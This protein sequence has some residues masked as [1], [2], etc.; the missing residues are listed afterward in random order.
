MFPCLSTT[1]VSLMLMY[2][3]KMCSLGDI[4]LMK[5]LFFMLQLCR[6]VSGSG[7]GLAFSFV[8]QGLKGQP[9]HALSWAAGFAVLSGAF[10]KVIDS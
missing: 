2:A 1:F 3:F 6:L 8:S 5:P 7:S 4:D 10:Y 9:A